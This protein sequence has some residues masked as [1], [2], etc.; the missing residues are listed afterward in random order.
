MKK[1]PKCLKQDNDSTRFCDHCGTELFFSE[2]FRDNA[3]TSDKKRTGSVV[4]KYIAKQFNQ[5]SGIGGKLISYIMNRQNRILYEE[6]L[7]LLAVTDTDTIL[8]IGCGNGYVM[9]MIARR[10]DC[11]LTGIDI[12]TDILKS[13]EKRNHKFV[14]DGRMNLMC[15]DI[16]KMSFSDEAF[17]K[18]YTI[19]TVY[20]WENLNGTMGEIWRV[21]KPGGKFINTL[22][23]NEMLDRFP[24]AQHGYKRFSID[25]LT[26]G[27]INAG[28]TVNVVPVFNSAA[29]CV[30]YRKQ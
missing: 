9:N 13:A 25:Q 5:P 7:R 14:K 3:S 29:L 30:L 27:G 2:R 10:Y 22:Y 8:D 28:F 16:G 4:N 21:L 15:Q 24:H 26:S 11:K 19:N 17:N 23:T 1:C 12:S 18:I 20:S 6:T